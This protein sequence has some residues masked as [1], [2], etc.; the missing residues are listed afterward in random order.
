MTNP[1]IIKITPQEDNIFIFQYIDRNGAQTEEKKPFHEFL[2]PFKASHQKQIQA[3]KKEINNQVKIKGISDKEVIQLSKQATIL[4]KEKDALGIQIIQYVKKLGGKDL[5]KTTQLFQQAFAHFINGKLDRALTV[6]DEAKMIVEATTAKESTKKKAETRILKAQILSLNNRSYEASL[7]YEMALTLYD[8][9]SNTLLV[10]DY[11]R[12]LRQFK[13]AQL[14]YQVCLEKAKSDHEE[15]T[16]LNHLGFLK[17]AKNKFKKAEKLFQ[18]ALGI[19]RNA[20]QDHPATNLPQVANTILNLAILQKAKNELAQSEK[21]Y[22]EALDIYR[23]LATNNAPTYLRHVANTLHNL[24]K[25]QE[26]KKEFDKAKQSIEEAIGI[27]Q[28]LAANSPT[29]FLP[30]VAITLNDLA[31]LQLAKKEF[32]PAEKSY[33]EAL[34]IYRKLVKVNPQAYLPKLG[35]TQIAMGIFYQQSKIDKKLSI[36]YLDEAIETLL[37]FRHF[38]NIR[39]QLNKAVKALKDWK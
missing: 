28:T 20:A 26:H 25:L 11:F 19:Y 21:S 34:E 9:W 38:T 39:K 10:A 29:N 16:T 23:K 13:K 33:Q 37:P 14:H 17:Q 32:D 1:K 8:D 12:D 18:E 15:A 3:L 31:H 4:E 6:L 24:S 7:N 35:L 30:R 36:Q 5:S 22:L 27:Y 2:K